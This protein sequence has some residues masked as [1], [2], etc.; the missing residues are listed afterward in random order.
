MSFRC[1]SEL[2]QLQLADWNLSSNCNLK[3][4]AVI[5]HIH[6]ALLFGQEELPL[7]SAAEFRPGGTPGRE[8]S[9]LIL[10]LRYQFDQTK[11]RIK[12]MLRFCPSYINSKIDSFVDIKYQ[13]FIKCLCV[14]WGV[15]ERDFG[16]NIK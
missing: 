5:K 8:I 6:H 3:P 10:C 7:N 15:R 12:V 2:L 16:T 1:D 11:T 4:H 14:L 9:S 13:I